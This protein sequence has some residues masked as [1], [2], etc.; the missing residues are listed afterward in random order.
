[1]EKSFGPDGK[2]IG[3]DGKK[4]D[5]TEKSW[6]LS[7]NSFEKLTGKLRSAEL[8]PLSVTVHDLFGKTSIWF[9]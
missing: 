1:M 8:N 9:K 2:K 6:H 7:K 4:S 5:L 3:P